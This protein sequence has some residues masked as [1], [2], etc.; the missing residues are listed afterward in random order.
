MSSVDHDD[1]VALK[2]YH[3]CIEYELDRLKKRYPDFRNGKK[4]SKCIQG[5]VDISKDVIDKNIAEGGM[6]NEPKVS[7][8][9]WFW[10]LIVLCVL[11]FCIGGLIVGGY[12]AIAD[13]ENCVYKGMC[14][15]TKGGN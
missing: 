2:Q 1:I 9:S 14:V 10:G 5:I 11:M 8:D 15:E 6:V 3:L 4:L 12:F 13:L 7:R